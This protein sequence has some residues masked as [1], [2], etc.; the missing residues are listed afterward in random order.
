VAW[1]LDITNVD[2]LDYDLLFERFLNP[3]RISMPDIDLDFCMNRRGEVIDYVRDK[4]GAENVAQIITFGTMAAKSVVRDVGRVLGHQYGF[5]DKISK[6]IPGGPG[7]TL[8]DAKKDSPQLAE[9]IKNDEEVRKIVEIGEKLEGL[10]RHAG[11][12]AAGVVITP[13]PVTNYVP[14]YRT[15]RDEIVT[16]FDMR[17]VEK[18]GLVKMD[19]LGLRTLTVIDD[20]VKSAK[21]VDGV[22]IDIEG[23][24]LDDPEV[25]RLFQE[26][27]TKGVFQFESGGMV[28][29]LRKARPTQFE[30]L[31]ALNALYRPGALDAGMVDEYVRRKNGTSKAKY[32]V[33]AM[34]DV[35]EETYGVIVYQEQVMQIAQQVAGYS[36]GQ[37]DLLRKAMGKKDAE[38]MAKER[39]GFVIGAVNNGYDKKKANEIFDYIEPF[40]R[41]GFNKSHSVAYALVAY[42]T[43]WLKVHYP[44]HFMAA[45]MSSEMDRTEA[46]VKF[47]G[48]AKQMGIEVLPPDV[49]ESNMYFTVVGP[50]IRFGLGAVKGVGEG[51]VES[52]LDARRRIGRYTSL[53]GFCEEV[54]L[55]ACNKKVLEALVKSGSFDFIGISRKALFEQL[56]STADSAQRTKDEKE[57]GQNSLF[58]LFSAAATPALSKAA[59]LP[60]HSTEWPED[61]RLKYEKET[62]GFYITGHPLN[63]FN[64]ELKLF[65]TATTDTLY[66]HVDETVNIGGIVSQ[67]KKSKIKKGPN[68][69]KLMAKFFLDDQAGSV[70]VV[71]FSDLYAKYMRW[72]DNG[73]AVLVTATVKDTGGQ[74]AGRSASLQSAEQS[75]QQI[76]DEYGGHPELR[77][78]R[79]SAYEL[80]LEDAED[81]RD[82]KEIEREKYGDRANN[83]SLFGG[84][85]EADAFNEA[86]ESIPEEPAAT[87]SFA[88]HAAAFHE[89]PI[90]PELSALEIVQLDG[91]RDRKVKE[92]A[93]E[94]PYARMSEDTVKK[95]RE[96]VEEHSGE[97]PVTVTITDL[98][99]AVAEQ[100]GQP[101]LRLKVNHHFRVQPGPALSTALTAVHASPRYVF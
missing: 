73:V 69:G 65:A 2:P 11:M 58:G 82:P 93:L 80:R 35:L 8:T 101:Q 3:E 25:F 57:R 34:K 46:V 40:A 79:I 59:A 20:A 87:S 5:V 21:L 63:K 72:L 45:L 99:P 13:E 24:P 18:M 43:A 39:G 42:Q 51:A 9:A 41:Y 31:A 60:Q 56:D 22:D 28:D 61:E 37:A 38:V 62:L 88:A 66:K 10:S 17:V 68:E 50:N 23:I 84:G 96:I 16:Q 55:R 95:I 77:G 94:V 12:H 7:V 26:G 44:R 74:Q 90:T 1:A 47:I 30:D 32:L 75:A 27:R 54:D 52:V 76:D 92:I 49:N 19:F 89:S 83:F 91:I 4:Y 98:P 71:V 86:V 64:D 14:L 33:P 6:M 67:M 29:L 36:L 100:T 15:N 81:D 70:E 48:E 78:A 53:L 85:S 97:I